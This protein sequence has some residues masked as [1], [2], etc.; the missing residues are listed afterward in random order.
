MAIHAGIHNIQ[1][2]PRHG[3]NGKKFKI[4]AIGF[5]VG[6]QLAFCVTVGQLGFM[7]VESHAFG[8]VAGL[9]L[10]GVEIGTVLVEISIRHIAKAA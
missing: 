5:F 2:I 9:E 10:L 1:P 6:L 4:T 8:Q 3:D 7:L